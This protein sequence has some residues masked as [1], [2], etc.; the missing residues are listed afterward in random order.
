MNSNKHPA[1]EITDTEYWN[2]HHAHRFPVLYSL[3]RGLSCRFSYSFNDLFRVVAL[4]V[5]DSKNKTFAELGCAPGYTLVELRNRLGVI[6]FGIENSPVG[7]RLNK[8]VFKRNAIPCDQV[9]LGDFLSAELRVKYRNHFDVVGSFG[10]VEHFT[11]PH[12]AIEGHIDLVKENGRVVV[13]VPN[14]GGINGMLVRFFD[15]GAL[16]RHNLQIMRISALKNMFPSDTVEEVFCGFC[17]GVNVGLATADSTGKTILLLLV[18]VAQFIL[19][20]P[21]LF[22]LAFMG[23]RVNAGWISPYIVYIGSKRAGSQIPGAKG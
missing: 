6:P 12:D 7:Y 9:I 11:S 10:L 8:E 13:M 20:N 4:A 5:R 3:F 19:I 18:L 15:K 2:K 14:F 17:G 16:A 23:V 21:L 1:T 22:L